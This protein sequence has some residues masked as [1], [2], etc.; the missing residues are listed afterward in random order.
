M[1]NCFIAVGEKENQ[2]KCEEQG[3][4]HGACTSQGREPYGFRTIAVQQQPVSRQHCQGGVVVR[5]PEENCGDN[6]M[7]GVG[8]GVG[9]DDQG[10]V[11]RR[12]AITDE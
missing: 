6:V 1:L 7:E 4:Y 2:G 11:D 12:N 3:K 9:E 10:Q 8:N 5:G